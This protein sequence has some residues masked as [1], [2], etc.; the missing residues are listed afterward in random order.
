[1]KLQDCDFELGELLDPLEIGFIEG[2]QFCAVIFGYGCMNA[3]TNV[4]KTNQ[5][6]KFNAAH[7]LV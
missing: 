4:L 7:H 5:L 2:D 1:L 3:I 6:S